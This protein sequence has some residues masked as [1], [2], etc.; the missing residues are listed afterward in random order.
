[1]RFVRI[2]QAPRAGMARQTLNAA[3][4]TDLKNSG[5]WRA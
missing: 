2:E 5:I 3:G 4:R 1:M